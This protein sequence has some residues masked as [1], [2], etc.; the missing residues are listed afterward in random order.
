[1]FTVANLCL[2]TA[3]AAS[4]GAFE[5]EFQSKLAALKSRVMPFTP[6]SSGKLEVAAMPA[7]NLRSAASQQ[8]A[9]AA[10]TTIASVYF[11]VYDSSDCST[12][13]IGGM[14]Y[15]TNICFQGTNDEGTKVSGMY[16]ATVDGTTISLTQS[17]YEGTKCSREAI[18]S[19]T[20]TF[21]SGLCGLKTMMMMV[22]PFLPSQEL[23]LVLQ[24]TLFLVMLEF[25]IL[26]PPVAV[27]I[28]NTRNSW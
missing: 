20:V 23:P 12:N 13:I 6:I 4:K 19:Q 10:S 21:T 15:G 1:M 11:E 2:L 17:L 8:I 18:Q 27:A 28:T 7:Q 16:A 25:W 14:G 22:L 5:N 26:T 9:V 24:F 3:V